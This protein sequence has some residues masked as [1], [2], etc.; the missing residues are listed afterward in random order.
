MRRPFEMA[1]RT[2][3]TCKD[4]TRLRRVMMPTAGR[5]QPRRRRAAAAGARAATS[6]PLLHRWV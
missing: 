5:P 6:A 2:H 1:S 4:R 3:L